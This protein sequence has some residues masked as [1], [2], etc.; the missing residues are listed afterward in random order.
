MKLEKILPTLAPIIFS[1]KFHIVQGLPPKLP[2]ILLERFTSLPINNTIAQVT[3]EELNVAHA[4]HKHLMIYLL[5][6][7]TAVL[8]RRAPL[9]L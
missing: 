1:N 8:G 2:L 4:I 5:L 7:N 6:D 3:T 9:L